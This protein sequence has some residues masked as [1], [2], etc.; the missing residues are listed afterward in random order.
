MLKDN[1]NGATNRSYNVHKDASEGSE[2]K[3]R[4]V[5]GRFTNLITDDGRYGPIWLQFT[6]MT[7]E[8]MA[9]SKFPKGVLVVEIHD[10]TQVSVNMM[11]I[12]VLCVFVRQILF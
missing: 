8:Q 4:G 10:M 5:K 2:K 1:V 3:F 7:E 9:S 12:V 11:G 6:G